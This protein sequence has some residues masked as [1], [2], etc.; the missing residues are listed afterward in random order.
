VKTLR[1][2]PWLGL[3]GPARKI[4][5]IDS[6]DLEEFERRF[7]KDME[8]RI[9]K[10]ALPEPYTGNLGKA[11]VL[12]L[13]QSPSYRAEDAAWHKKPVFRQIWLD[14]LLQKESKY[15]FYPLNPEL[16]GSP[17]S[18]WWR[19]KIKH[20]LRQFGDERISQKIAVVQWFPYHATRSKNREYF[21]KRPLPSQRFAFQIVAERLSALE[22]PALL[23]F[24]GDAARK[25]WETSIA[26]VGVSLGSVL[27]LN[28]QQ[29]FNISPGNLQP[30]AWERVEALLSAP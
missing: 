24:G 30:R 23:V 12:I 27:R 8:A 15:P 14:N 11:R 2:N 18:D 22:P 19:E 21:L 3:L 26:S 13:A 1:H 10:D 4:L 17:V 25:T 7:G 20:L 16:T 29:S 9:R 28:S 6:E 5:Q